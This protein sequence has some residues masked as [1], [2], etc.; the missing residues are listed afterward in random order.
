MSAGRH[1]PMTSEVADK[2][3]SRLEHVLSVGMRNMTSPKLT[4]YLKFVVNPP[5]D[6]RDLSDILRGMSS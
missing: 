6:V 3:G 4:A 2:S 1:A 5:K